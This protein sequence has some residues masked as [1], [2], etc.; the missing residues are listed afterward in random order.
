[1]AKPAIQLHPAISL[2]EASP[3]AR[4]LALNSDLYCEIAEFLYREADLMDRH[5]YQQW[6]YLWCDDALYWLPSN[7]EDIN[8]DHA[9]SI[10]YEH[11]H[12]I[13]DRVFR[14]TDKRMHSQAPKSRLMRVLSDIRVTLEAD[15]N[16]I[17]QSNFVLGEMR[18]GQQD[19]LFGHSTHRLV[20]RDGNWAIRAKKV[21][22]LNNDAPMRNVTYLL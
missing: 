22:L 10:I 5:E 3:N 1:M 4:T 9:V 21:F 12:Q 15:G 7:A 19:V 13:S 16:V 17:A 18:N 14:L 8:P 20:Q 2:F 11:R 6:E